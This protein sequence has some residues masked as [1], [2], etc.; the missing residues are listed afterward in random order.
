M[1]SLKIN[2]NPKKESSKMGLVVLEM[3][4]LGIGD[5]KVIS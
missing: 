3:I 1:L 2:L 4:E 5:C